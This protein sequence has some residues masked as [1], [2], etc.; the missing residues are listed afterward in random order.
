MPDGQAPMMRFF[1]DITSKDYL[2]KFFLYKKISIEAVI[3]VS[4]MRT[5]NAIPISAYNITKGIDIAILKTDENIKI[6]ENCFLYQNW[7]IV[8]TQ[9]ILLNATTNGSAESICITAILLVNSD[10]K[11]IC[12]KVFAQKNS[13]V[14]KTMVH[15]LIMRVIFFK[16]TIVFSRD[17]ISFW[18]ILGYI[19]CETDHMS[20]WTAF[21]SFSALA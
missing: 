2:K 4:V 21:T 6:Y 8:S 15:I 20:H 12:I 17:W 10:Q 11:R 13:I 18:E 16:K 19:A 9:K 1:V 3:S 7:S 14:D 5:A